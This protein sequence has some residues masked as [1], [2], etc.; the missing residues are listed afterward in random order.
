MEMIRS[1]RV[2][3][4]PVN[5]RVFLCMARTEDDAPFVH[6]P[7]SL[8]DLVVFG[9]HAGLRAAE[10]AKG[11]DYPSPPAGAEGPA[12]SQFD[13]LKNGSGKENAFTI[14]RRFRRAF[15]ASLNRSFDGFPRRYMGSPQS[16]TA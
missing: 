15:S 2:Y 9:K 13:A 8:L 14:S 4:P 10:Y 1:F 11:S 3:M 7:H 12:T 5:A 6:G 16:G